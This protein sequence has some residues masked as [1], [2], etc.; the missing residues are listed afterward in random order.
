ML[1][2]DIILRTIPRIVL[3]PLTA[4]SWVKSLNA[5]VRQRTPSAR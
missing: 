1:W 2:V 4:L 5:M 3:M